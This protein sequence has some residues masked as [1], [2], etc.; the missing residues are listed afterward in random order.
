VHLHL[1]NDS[2]SFHPVHPLIRAFGPRDLHHA[3]GRGRSLLF[4]PY[5][6]AICWPLF[7]QQQFTPSASA[8]GSGAC[9]IRSIPE[10]SAATGAV[11]PQL[12]T[13]QV[14]ASG[15][16]IAINEAR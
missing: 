14:L 13:P 10:T 6:Y 3:K 11:S 7:P 16:A 5:G 15:T 2:P 8:K 1:K 4:S 9:A 12:I